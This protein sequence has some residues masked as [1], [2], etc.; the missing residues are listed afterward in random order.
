MHVVGGTVTYGTPI[1]THDRNLH[2]LYAELEHEAIGIR[3]NEA[4]VE[5]LNEVSLD[6]ATYTDCYNSL[7]DEMRDSQVQNAPY[8]FE[9]YFNKM[10]D[11]MEI[12][13]NACEKVNAIKPDF[14]KL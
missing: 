8:S 2:N 4:I 1:S 7:I 11:S 10:L 13:I 14:T 6:G 12:W 3:L 9:A 5:V